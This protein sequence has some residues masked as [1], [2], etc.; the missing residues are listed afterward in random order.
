MFRLHV[1]FLTI[2]AAF[3]ELKLFSK[4]RGSFSGSLVRENSRPRKLLKKTFSATRLDLREVGSFRSIG[5]A[6]AVQHRS[7]SPSERSTA[8][9][10]PPP[11]VESS[12]HPTALVEEPIRETGVWLQDAQLCPE[13][14][15]SVGWKASQQPTPGHLDLILHVPLPIVQDSEHRADAAGPPRSASKWRRLP[16][17]AP[18]SLDAPAAP[19]NDQK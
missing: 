6:S 3:Q 14:L 2:G 5:S 1:D 9:T 11:T 13:D 15:L 16:K 10:E 19:N 7:Y 17:V 18:D 12:N 8:A 4:P